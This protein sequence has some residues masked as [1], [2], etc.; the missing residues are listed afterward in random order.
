MNLPFSREIEE[1]PVWQAQLSLDLQYKREKTRLVASQH[2]G[3][4]YVQ[5]PFYPEGDDLAHVYLLHPPG[6]IVSG[7]ELEINVNIGE[8]SAALIT[9]P[10]AARAYRARPDKLA[11]RQVNRLQVAAGASLEWFPLETIVFNDARLCADTHIQ[12]AEGA[13]LACWEVTSLGLPASN[14]SFAKGS[15]LQRYCVSRACR[16]LFID[17]LEISDR[18]R[19]VLHARAGFQSAPVSGFFVMGPFTEPLTDEQLMQL[20]DAITAMSL[21]SSAGVSRVGDLIVGRYLGESA[22]TARALFVSWWQQLRPLLLGR[23]ACPPES[24]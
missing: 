23:K 20:R 16:P 13:S 17:R 11:Q 9:T 4:L 12:L 21:S 1:S 7:D 15:F 6:G 8:V 18:S 10:G 5:K 19:A 22:E 2:K 3:P 14:E 24:G